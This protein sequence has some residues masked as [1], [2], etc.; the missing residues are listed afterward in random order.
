MKE[1]NLKT[2][3]KNTHLWKFQKKDPNIYFGF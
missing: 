2:K 1:W 3:Q